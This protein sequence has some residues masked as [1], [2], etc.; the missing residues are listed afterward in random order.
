GPR[1]YSNYGFILLGRIVEQVSGLSYDDYVERNIFAPAGMRSTGN[2]AETVPLPKRAIAY[3][4]SGKGIKRADATLPVRGTSA[5]GGYSTV[6]DFNR[7]MDALLSNRLLRA[8]T[9]QQLTTGGAKL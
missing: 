1:A 3:M 8:A 6:G 2:L 4:G 7:F 5:G 9:F